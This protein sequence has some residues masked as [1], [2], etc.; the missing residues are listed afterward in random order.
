MVCFFFPLIVSHAWAIVLSRRI[1]IQTAPVISVVDALIILSEM[2]GIIC[3][4]SPESSAFRAVG[5]NLVQ[6][7]F[8]LPSAVQR[9]GSCT[10]CQ[11]TSAV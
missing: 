5:N 8:I 9:L 7:S 1:L 3:Y 4:L 10:F 2:Q 6:G 11:I